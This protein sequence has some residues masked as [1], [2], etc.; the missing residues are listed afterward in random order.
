MSTSKGQIITANEPDVS[1]REKFGFLFGHPIAHSLSPLTHQT[2]YDSIGY[3]W[4]QFPLPSTDMP[5]F[6]DL[7]RRPNFFGESHHLLVAE[8]CC[9]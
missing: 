8:R 9:E 3:N 2:V 6:L 4:Q 1:S 5:Q 7:M